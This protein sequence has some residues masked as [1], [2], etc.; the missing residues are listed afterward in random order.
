MSNSNALSIGSAMDFNAKYAEGVITGVIG[1]LINS[2][3]KLMDSQ[4]DAMNKFELTTMNSAI[5]QS[6]NT[7]AL[8]I[9]EGLANFAQAGANF[10]AAGINAFSMKGL[11]DLKDTFNE[12][13]KPIESK[14][15]DLDKQLE[16]LNS[17]NQLEQV[18]PDSVE[19]PSSSSIDSQKN[20]ILKQREYLMHRQKGLMNEYEHDSKVSERKLN[21]M[22][23]IATSLT[24]LGNGIATISRN[25]SSSTATIDQAKQGTSSAAQKEIESSRDAGA[26]TVQGLTGVN[27][28]AS[29][30]DL[31]RA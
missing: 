1:K 29:F 10:G 20:D 9:V 13:N 19:N 5:H 6:A 7:Q 15:N 31:G 23:Q 4:K 25:S 27:M 12:G 18:P 3:N 8:G 17:P 2:E 30:A 24:P 16:G 21:A 26:S 14:L 22:N 28:Y 11:K